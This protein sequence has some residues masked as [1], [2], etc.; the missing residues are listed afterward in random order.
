MNRQDKIVIV[1][2]ATR[3]EQLV[4]RYNTW[5]QARFYLQHMDL[6]PAEYQAEHE[7]YQAALMRVRRDLEALDWPVQALERGLIPNYL[8]GPQDVVVTVGPDGL[9]VNTAKYLRGQSIVAINPDPTRIDGIL[10]PFGVEDCAAIVREAL[11]GRATVTDITMAEAVL[12]DGQRL[13][14]FNDFLVGQRSHV[15]ARYRLRWGKKEETQSSS[16]ILISTGVGSTG[17]L[18]STRNMRSHCLDWPPM[19]IPCSCRR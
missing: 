3:L 12:N 19:V 2:R 11:T 6:D 7:T 8:F 1:T 14:A 16:G 4:A 13:L 10:L 18:S 15:S 9:V 17:W 5:P